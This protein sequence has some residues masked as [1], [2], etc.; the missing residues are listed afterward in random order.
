MEFLGRGGAGRMSHTPERQGTPARKVGL[1]PPPHPQAERILAH[2]LTGRM[3]AATF[4]MDEEGM[5]PRFRTPLLRV[6]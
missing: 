5:S 6:Q 2:S 3:S 4:S 1:E